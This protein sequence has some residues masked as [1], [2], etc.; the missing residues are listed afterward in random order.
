MKNRWKY[1]QATAA[2]RTAIEAVRAD[3]RKLNDVLCCCLPEGAD[4]DCAIECLEDSFL[5]AECAILLHEE[6]KAE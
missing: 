5:R 4:R 1:T 6:P 2:Q 3:Y